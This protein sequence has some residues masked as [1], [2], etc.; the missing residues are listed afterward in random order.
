MNKA[1]EQQQVQDVIQTHIPEQ[2]F[3]LN[4]VPDTSIVTSMPQLVDAAITIL[5]DLQ[6]TPGAQWDIIFA[7]EPGS[8]KT[9]AHWHLIRLLNGQDFF[10]ENRPD[11]HLFSTGTA[12]KAVRKLYPGDELGHN[13]K[14]PDQRRR[15]NEVLSATLRSDLPYGGIRYWQLHPVFNDPT[16]DLEGTTGVKEVLEAVQEVENKTHRR[17]LLVLQVT[18]N[19]IHRD[20]I[21][22]RK[23]LGKIVAQIDSHKDP[24]RLIKKA[25]KLLKGRASFELTPENLKEFYLSSATGEIVEKL[26]NTMNKAL[27]AASARGDIR[28]IS[29]P[30]KINTKRVREPR[31]AEWYDLLG[32]KYL[33]NSPSRRSHYIVV[34]PEEVPLEEIK[35]QE[36][37]VPEYTPEEIAQILGITP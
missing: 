9:T 26:R 32:K 4:T 15:V 11:Q 36:D 10:K 8:G 37:I 24:Q 25:E 18:N 28:R 22:L 21:R 1:L 33:Q 5:E 23:E 29:N 35:P 6:Q 19:K 2:T 20:A 7:A 13:I 31:Q 14:T 3:A 12:Y 34:L 16:G 17:L 27:L 30:A